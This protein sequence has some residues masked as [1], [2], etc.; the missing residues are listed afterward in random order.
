MARE[1]KKGADVPPEIAKAVLAL[2]TAE[3]D[4][5][6]AYDQWAHGHRPEKK[7]SLERAE[8]QIDA[9]EREIQRLQGR[10]AR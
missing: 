8:R 2:R 3:V 1:Q 5:A 6:Q 4:F 10:D 7:A 9:A